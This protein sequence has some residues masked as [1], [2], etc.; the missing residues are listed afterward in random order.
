MFRE[1]AEA[2][3]FINRKCINILYFIFEYI[4]LIDINISMSRECIFPEK[5]NQGKY[6]LAR[7]N[8]TVLLG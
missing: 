5:Q 6:A 4:F 2:H 7:Y 1:Q 3:E 8:T